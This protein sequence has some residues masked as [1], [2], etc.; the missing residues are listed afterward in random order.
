MPKPESRIVSL[1]IRMAQRVVDL[2]LMVAI[3]GYIILFALQ[4]IPSSPINHSAWVRQLH[5]IEDP[6]IAI[7]AGWVG[8][9][10]PARAGFSFLPLGGAFGVWLVKIVVDALFLAA[11]RALER[12]VTG[13]PSAVGAEGWSHENAMT[14]D[15][16]KA[17][18]EL[19]RRYREIESALRSTGRKRCVFLAV[20]GRP[21][22]I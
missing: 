6:G 8:L 7:P 5:R 16:E 12:V 4:F 14:A 15:S 11:S 19:L 10:W 21:G 22:V 3:A 17:R 18:E 13:K 20:D 1:P 9:H 2:I